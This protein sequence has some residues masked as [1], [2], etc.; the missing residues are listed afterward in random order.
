MRHAGHIVGL[1]LLV[2]VPSCDRTAPPPHAQ[3]TVPPSPIGNAP[4]SPT[5]QTNPPLE[6]PPLV[7]HGQPRGRGLFAS[8]DHIDV[9]AAAQTMV[10]DREETVRVGRQID[11]DHAGLLIHDVINE[12]G[13]LVREP[14]VI[15][16]PHM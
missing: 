9:I 15:L 1:M 12:A 10:G 3:Q 11:A 6:K 8:Y 4:A 16:P 2:L 14:I 5:A 7:V 13:I